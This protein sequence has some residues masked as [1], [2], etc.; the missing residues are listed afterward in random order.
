MSMPY[1]TISC[2]TCDFKTSTT[3]LWGNFDYVAPNGTKLNI[4]R[5]YGWFYD[6]QDIRAIEDLSD[7][8]KLKNDIETDIKKIDDIRKTDLI[9]K[10]LQ[11]LGKD[12]WRINSLKEDIETNQRRLEFLHER[13][14]PSKCLVC[15]SAEIQIIHIPDPQGDNVDKISEFRHQNCGGN[16]LVHNSKWWINAALPLREYDLDGIFIET[17]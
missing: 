1:K 6:C 8:D 11:F 2:D 15:S 5:T 4:N 17:R 13:K 16:L 10:I 14:T 9:G 12:K 3:C 7:A